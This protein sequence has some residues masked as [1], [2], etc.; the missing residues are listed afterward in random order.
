V[1]A[2]AQAVDLRYSPDS[3]RRRLA[4][5]V[6]AAWPTG[7]AGLV[8]LGLLLLGIAL[9]VLAIIS[10]WPTTTT[11]EDGYQNFAKSNPFMDPQHPAGYALILAALGSVTHEVAVPVLLQQ[12]S[13]IASALLLGAATRRVTGSAWAALLPAGIILLDPD[14]IF[15]EHAI[16]SESWQV[17]A[18]SI[19]LYAA[20]RT[21]DEPDPWWRWPLL[22]GV[23]LGISVTIRTAGLLM[24]PV[25]VL[26]LI[27][28][29]PQR[30]SGWRQRWRA[31]VAAAGAAA[32]VLLAY[33]SA[34]ATYGQRFGIAPSPGWY[35]Y[36]RVAQFADCSRFTA[37]PGTAALCE[38]TPASQRPSGYYYMFE[39][40]APA[41]RLFGGF[42]RDDGLIGAWA[43]RALRAQFGDFLRTAWAYLRSYWVPGWL[44]ARLKPSTELDPQLDFTYPGNAI[45]V[46]V[47]HLD[48]EHFYDPF[49]AHR[50]HWGLQLL[51]DFQL[52]IRFGATAL[53]VTTLLTL[54]GLVVGTRRSR[55]GVLL[56]GVGGLSLI[57]AP[58]LTG[59]YSGR[60]TVPM[61]GPLMAAAAITLTEIPRSRFR[62][63]L[64]RRRRAL[65]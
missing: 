11:L 64:E 54:I 60:Y 37:P 55:A 35:L 65:T 18:T 14:E 15:L 59:T 21:L 7:A 49:T 62:S 29:Q 36:G 3:L 30:F 31:P 61:A 42:G 22:T 44:P 10:L 40:Q 27:M 13:G 9:R 45:Y 8:L 63:E 17:L 51:R 48:L 47:M 6:R 25:V 16:M 34:N 26:A 43:E 33:S 28:Y 46:A 24:I 57:A 20:V 19:G 12:L 23:A 5:A 2:P 39:P 41:P 53:L 52:R 38:K 56:F 32:I 4:Q 58:A 50:L 1:T